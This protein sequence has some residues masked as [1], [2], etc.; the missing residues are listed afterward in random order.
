MTR[1]GGHLVISVDALAVGV[2]TAR[3]AGDDA[4]LEEILLKGTGR[5]FHHASHPFDVRFFDPESGKELLVSVADVRNEYREAVDQA[6]ME[7]RR[8][9]K[10]QGIDYEVVQTDRP[11]GVALR[12]YLRKR[13]RLG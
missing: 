1:A 8:A 10:P 12:A 7:W 3:R 11:L 4:L 13:E 5:A 9:L 2:R 6:L